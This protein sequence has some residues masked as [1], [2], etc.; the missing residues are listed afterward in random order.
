MTDLERFEAARLANLREI[1]R[2]KATAAL[3]ELRRQFENG[4]HPL[5]DVVDEYLRSE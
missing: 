1:K 5:F 4:E 2:T 3:V